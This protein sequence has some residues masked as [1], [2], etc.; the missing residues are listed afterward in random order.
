M[1]A[2]IFR[3]V[4]R[5]L[6]KQLQTVP[7][8]LTPGKPQAEECWQTTNNW[9]LSSSFTCINPTKRVQRCRK[10]HPPHTSTCPDCWRG[11]GYTSDMLTPAGCVCEDLLVSMSW[12][13]HCLLCPLASGQRRLRE[14]LLSP[15]EAARSVAD[16]CV[17][18]GRTCQ[19][20]QT[21]VSAANYIQ[22]FCF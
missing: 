12:R 15:D 10:Q 9:S 20:A 7:S 19:E 17:W 13:H 22:C 8:C 2:L 4:S 11:E 6:G 16:R 1:T 3:T 14:G 21:F 18:P 5:A